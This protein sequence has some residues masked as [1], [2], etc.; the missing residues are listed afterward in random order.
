M[1][2]FD[3]II[4][5]ETIKKELMQICDMIK[6]KEIYENLGAKLPHGILLH[7][8][9]GLGKSL[10]AKCFIEESGLKT[11]TVRRNKGTDDFMKEI[12]ETFERAKENTPAIVFLDD[13]DKF[14]NEDE[15]RCDAEEYVAIQSGIDNVKESEV[16]VIGTA[17]NVRKLPESLTRSGRFD[18]KI[19]IPLPTSDDSYKIIKHYLKGKKVSDD[20][21]IEDIAM[22]IQHTSCAELETVLN[23]AA[24]LAAYSRRNSISTK[25]I[26]DTVLRMKYD[27]PDNFVK[28]SEDTTRKV[29]IHEAGHLVMCEVLCPG[30]IGIASIRSR[31]GHSKGGFVRKC[32]ELDRRPFEILVSLAG[33][34]A[35]EMYYADTRA[36]GC[37]SDLSMA[38][39][40]IRT[41]VG[42]SCTN[43]FEFMDVETRFSVSMSQNLNSRVEAIIHS[44]LERY[45]FKARDTLIKNKEFLEKATDMLIEKETLLHSDIRALRESVTITEVFI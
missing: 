36:S 9:P 34:A 38:A 42:Q 19:L 43:G 10:M 41:A 40:Q 18:R 1:S 20:I 12:T 2:K 23:E 28:T 26:V 27:A 33:K 15:K 13:M 25:D 30:S 21:N 16:F 6:N 35:V 7:G 14:A 24:I 29:A 45:L 37:Q 44:E 22:M 17:N 31:E 39:D 5:Y 4:G 32:R 11:Y 8:E 3:N